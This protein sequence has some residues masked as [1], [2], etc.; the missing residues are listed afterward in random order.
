MALFQILSCHILDFFNSDSTQEESRGTSF[1]FTRYSNVGV[2]HFR[3][4]P[5]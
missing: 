3:C 2:P 4:F 1:D 5:E